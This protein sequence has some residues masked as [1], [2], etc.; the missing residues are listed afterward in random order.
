MNHLGG[1]DHSM[2]MVTMRGAVSRNA[3]FEE[4]PDWR[5]ADLSKLRDEL[6]A[7]DWRMD[8]LD[9]LQSWSFV[10]ANILEAE[11]KCVPK[12]RRR[13]GCR[14]LWMQQ[15]VMRIIRKKRRLWSTYKKTK[16]Y[17]EYLAY[18]KVE[19]ETKKIVKQAKK[20]FERKLAKEAKKSPRCSIPTLEQK[21][22]TNQAWDH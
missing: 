17:S 22:Q 14:P 8:G 5:N 12:K 10:K 2:V 21:L 20:K 19:S 18:K 7:V 6:Q 4:V 11:D 15:N 13:V 9:T 1:S 3:T 16:D